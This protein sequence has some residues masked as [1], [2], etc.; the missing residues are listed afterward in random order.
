MSK[1]LFNLH[2][3][4]KAKYGGG[5]VV[6][7]RTADYFETFGSDAEA[8]EKCLSEKCFDRQIEGE[9]IKVIGFVS[10]DLDKVLPKIIRGGNRV[11]V[12]EPVDYSFNK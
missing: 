10:Y 12:C 6:L 11:A 8:V 3:E 4:L 9:V 5:T 2:K 1:R 7:I